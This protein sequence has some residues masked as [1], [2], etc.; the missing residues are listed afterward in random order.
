MN[1]RRRIALAVLLVLT[2]IGPV[3]DVSAQTPA[4]R[5]PITIGVLVD[6]FLGLDPVDYIKR[7]RLV[8]LK[9]SFA[10]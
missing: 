8:T 5:G 9:G 1:G 2:L 3:A 10:K 4:P 6:Q 7:P